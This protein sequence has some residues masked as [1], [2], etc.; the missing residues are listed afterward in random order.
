MG[1]NHFGGESILIPV[2][3]IPEDAGRRAARLETKERVR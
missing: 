3:G 1:Q 2:D